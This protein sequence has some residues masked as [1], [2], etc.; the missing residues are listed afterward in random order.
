[1]LF[2]SY[3]LLLQQILLEFDF[4]YGVG[5][6][7]Q[8]YGLLIPKMG[9]ETGFFGQ[10]M[11]NLDLIYDKRRNNTKN[12]SAVPI[13]YHLGA[14]NHDCS[15]TVP[16]ASLALLTGS[17]SGGK[18]MCLRT[19]AHAIIL[20]QMGFPSLGTLDFTPYDE[21]YYFKKSN[22]QISAGAFE[23]TL[24]QF[25]Q[26]A[27]SNSSKIIFADELE[28]ITEPNAASKVLAGIF[29][30]FLANPLNTGIFVTHIVDLI[31]R[32]FT[33]EQRGQIRIDGIEAEGLDKDLNLIINRNPKFNFVAKST[34]ELILT[35]LAKS[36]SPQQQEFFKSILSKFENR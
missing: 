16:Q 22:G 24:K 36:G 9:I 11:V 10:E 17:N 25:V 12:N 2:R 1:M 8:D 21:I 18:T 33:Q 31:V 7:A 23:T 30:L 14:S 4:F 26:L 19:C 27:Q 15:Q 32:E 34:P 20:A 29:S 35:R 6:F 28:S 3:L 13:S 5:Q